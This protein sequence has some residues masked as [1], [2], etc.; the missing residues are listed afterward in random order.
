MKK[1]LDL[2]LK[3][4]FTG[5]VSFPDSTSSST[6]ITYTPESG[7]RL[8]VTRRGTIHPE[9]LPTIHGTLLTG[10]PF[11]LS[12][13]LRT[14]A[15]SIDMSLWEEEWH[16]DLLRLGSATSPDTTAVRAL[17]FTTHELN[18][19]C[20][21]TRLNLQPKPDPYNIRLTPPAPAA[22]SYTKSRCSCAI[23]HTPQLDHNFQ[24]GFVNFTC[25]RYTRIAY[26][27]PQS[28][29]RLLTDANGLRTIFSLLSGK[30][31]AYKEIAMFHGTSGDSQENIVFSRTIPPPSKQSPHEYIPP[32]SLYSIFDMWATWKKK[33]N[34]IDEALF[35]WEYYSA[36]NNHQLD[37]S[38]FSIISAI[39]GLHRNTSNDTEVPQ[40][41][42]D[43]WMLSIS[44]AMQSCK[45]HKLTQKAKPALSRLNEPSFRTRIKSTL[46]TVPGYWDNV[47]NK[48]R[49]LF[50]NYLCDTRNSLAHSLLASERAGTKDASR[51]A[52]LRT[53][54]LRAL[55]AKLLQHLGADSSLI[56]EL[57]KKDHH[58]RTH[59][60]LASGQ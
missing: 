45:Q 23:L 43:Q 37:A 29:N 28:A 47:P 51:K 35:T 17:E 39:E 38:L 18:S 13:C 49:R 8:Q 36:N 25:N 16:A 24:E 3:H 50:V 10:E 5:L 40:A 20:G 2:D 21:S 56:C 4:V 32:I 22:L 30:A 26:A 54:L 9:A 31:M 42:F 55:R 11:T 15:N 12:G 34:L 19:L 7:I 52:A 48:E 59:I 53:V 60:T 41:E 1:P 44:A 58:S 14:R 46:E 57:V 33:R 27:R 6:T